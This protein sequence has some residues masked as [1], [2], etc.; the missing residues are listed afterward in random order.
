M[1]RSVDFSMQPVLWG[2]IDVRTNEEGSVNK[3]IPCN[4]N[5][6]ALESSLSLDYGFYP[7]FSL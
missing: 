4:K 1:C 7:S 2:K 5:T 6:Q 3:W